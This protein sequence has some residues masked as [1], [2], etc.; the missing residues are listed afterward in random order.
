MIR[1]LSKKALQFKMQS[2][3]CSCDAQVYVPRGKV[4]TVPAWVKDDPIFD[5][6]EAEGSLEVIQ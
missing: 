4:T 2:A 1:V 6:C 5:L 3:P